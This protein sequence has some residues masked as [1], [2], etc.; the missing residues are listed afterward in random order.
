MLTGASAAAPRLA[1]YLSDRPCTTNV[2]GP[3]TCHEQHF[4]ARQ[5]KTL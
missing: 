2:K 1:H 3:E 4:Q 5:A